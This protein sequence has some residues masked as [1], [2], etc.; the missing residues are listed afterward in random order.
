MRSLDYMLAEIRSEK[1]KPVCKEKP[2]P[3]TLP[4]GCKLY[5]FPSAGKPWRIT[6][7]G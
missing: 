2:K 4:S 6:P 7:M 1:A 3:I 5:Q